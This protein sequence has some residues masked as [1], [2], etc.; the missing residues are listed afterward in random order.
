[1]SIHILPSKF[2]TPARRTNLVARPRLLERLE[3]G[4]T[5]KLT[6]VS[7]PAGYGKSTLLAEWVQQSEIPAAW[8]SLDEGDNDPVRFWTTFVAALQRLNPLDGAWDGDALLD[9]L[10]TAPDTG[11]KTFLTELLSQLAVIQKRFIL[12]LDDFHTVTETQI[13]EGLIYVLDSLPS[14]FSGLHLVISSRSDPPWPLARLRV[15]EELSEVRAQDLRFSLDEAAQFLNEVMGLAL[16]PEEITALES[17]TE[18]WVAGL[19][20]AAVSMRDRE[21]KTGFIQAFTGSH[22]YVIDY[23]MEEVLQRQPPE[24]VDFLLKTSILERMNSGLCAAVVSSSLPGSSGPST[25][26]RSVERVDCQSILESLEHNNLFLNALDDQRTWYRYHRLFADLL[27]NR[28]Q[29]RHP[30]LAPDLHR[31][32]SKWYGQSGFYGEAIHHALKTEDWTFAADIGCRP[33]RMKSSVR[34]PCC[35]LPRP[36]PRHAMRMWI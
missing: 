14:G 5:G 23:L 20:M 25:A 11:D 1:V 9:S 21:D 7:A 17:R 33:C 2:Y 18:G 31:R 34:G 29:T 28:L 8:L 30:G 26:D 22:R 6:L 12:I 4:V 32:A 27:K 19:Q 36:G 10:Q 15:R 16:S 35:V 3:A 13:Q 24:I